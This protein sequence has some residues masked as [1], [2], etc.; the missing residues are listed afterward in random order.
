MLFTHPVSQHTDRKSV[1]TYWRTIASPSASIPW[2]CQGHQV[3][4][5]LGRHT[6]H[7]FAKPRLLCVTFL[8]AVT[9]ILKQGI[10]GKALLGSLCG[11]SWWRQGNHGR[12]H[13]SL[14]LAFTVRKQ[15]ELHTCRSC[16]SSLF[17]IYVAGN[18]SPW[19]V[20]AYFRG[21]IFPCHLT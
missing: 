4:S 16:R 11:Y 3:L 8:F 10:L 15:R 12:R 20:T 9:E 21:E 2:S 19:D 17:L 7:L 13:G 6:S 5:P 18:P 14:L 1:P